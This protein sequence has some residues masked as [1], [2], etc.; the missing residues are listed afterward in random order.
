MARS[1]VTGGSATMLCMKLDSLKVELSLPDVRYQKN[2]KKIKMSVDGKVKWSYEWT[3]TFAPPLGQDLLTPVSSTIK[4]SLSGKRRIR[5]HLIG[6]YSGRIIDFLLDKDKPLTLQDDRHVTCATITMALSP[7]AD[8]QQAL[9]ASVDASL[10]RLDINPM[11]AEGL[12]NVDQAISAMETVDYAVETCGQYIAPLGQALR[13]MTKLIDNV[14]EAHPLLK[15]GWTLLSSV[16]KAVQEQRLNDENV[17]GLAES[18]RELVGVAGDCPVA[19]IK[20]TPHVIESIER[21]ALE[22]ASL[23]DECTQSS[24]MMRLG[25]AQITDSKTRITACQ[26]AL[27]DLYDKLRTRIIAYTAKRVKEMK[28]GIKEMQDD[29][30]RRDAQKLSE[31]IREWLKPHDSSVNHKSARDTHV[32]GTGSWIAT[33]ERFQKWLDEAGTTMWISGPPGFGKTVLFSTSVEVVL[34]HASAQGTSCC[35]AYSYFDARESGG[36]S[37]KLETL[38]RSILGQLCFKQAEIP[39]AMKRLYGVDGKEHPQPTVLQLR[40]TLGEVVKGFDDVYILIDALD[41][42]DSQGELL[43]WMTSLQ[44]TTQG[45][46][47]LATSRPE[48]TIEERMSNS[49]HIRIFLSSELLDNDIK[50]YVDERVEASKDLK[51]MMTEEMRKKLRVKGDGMFRLVAFWI[52]EL[53]RCLSPKAVTDTLTRLPTS[54]NEMYALMVSK[55]DPNYLPYARAIMGWLLSSVRQLKL[56]EIATVV[57][58]DFSDER[59][60]FDKDRCF[61]HPEAVLDVCGGLVVMSQDR[62]TLAHLTVKEFLLQQES[63]LH[64]NEPDAHSL[65]AQ[66]CLTYLL[67]LSQPHVT[68]DV[69]EF[70]LHDYAVQNWMEHA[71]ST[72]DIENT[73]SVIHKLALEVLHPEYETF[74]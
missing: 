61:A 14:A 71:S 3:N 22:V 7:V 40:T 38:L 51:S 67:D 45:L 50:T 43:D 46:H 31:Q 41:E 18:L 24:F 33:D 64:V 16:Y 63:L 54:L 30:K 49:S 42:C 35:C 69:G 53:K 39:E 72:R 19:E 27:K 74:Q 62:V 70:P 68:A 28:E 6:S 55:I 8:Y 13:L 52:D 29:A 23:I 5:K 48:R 57:G 60:A 25:K 20:G 32:E 47:L 10:A 9:L 65:I 44:L 34:R 56:E 17:R 58:F 15:V 73:Q 2:K 1:N 59:P 11:L 36:A 12:D 21:F 26:A 4:I 66:S 37:R